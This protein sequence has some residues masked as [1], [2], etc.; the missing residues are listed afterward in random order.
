MSRGVRLDLNGGVGSGTLWTNAAGTVQVPT[1]PTKE[2]YT[3]GGWY[4]DE[5]LTIPWNFDSAVS[6]NVVLYAKWNVISSTA[7]A[8]AQSTQTVTLNGKAVELQG[9][10]L[11]ADN[12]GDVTYVKLRDVAALLDG[13]SAQFNVEWRNGAIYV[14]GGKAY[15]SRNG[16]ELKAITVLDSGFR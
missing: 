8:T 13:T 6:G 11:K 3:F 1:N 4:T 15:T 10:T 2:G 7:A 9:Y 5:A 12:G 16:T 14:A